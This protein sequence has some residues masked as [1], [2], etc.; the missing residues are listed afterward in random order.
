M[1]RNIRYIINH[2]LLINNKRIG[3]GTVDNVIVAWDVKLTEA[4][5]GKF[6]ISCQGKND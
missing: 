6:G 5:F 1:N 4:A 2:K 3:K